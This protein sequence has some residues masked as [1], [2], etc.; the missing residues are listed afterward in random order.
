VTPGQVPNV[1][2][3][4]QGLP[5]TPSSMRPSQS[6]SEPSQLSSVASIA[7]QF[8][9]PPKSA[10]HVSTPRHVPSAFVFVHVRT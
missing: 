10:S 8:T 9:Q 2:V 3:V 7:E 5:P 6:L 1:F 4:V